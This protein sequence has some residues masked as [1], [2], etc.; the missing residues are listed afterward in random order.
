VAG[1][2]KRRLTEP[3]NIVRMGMADIAGSTFEWRENGAHTTDP[4]L[5]MPSSNPDDDAAAYA[6]CL[7][8][9]QPIVGLNGNA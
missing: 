7:V 6:A 3:K 1:T 4:D 5:L 8:W 2:E 9:L